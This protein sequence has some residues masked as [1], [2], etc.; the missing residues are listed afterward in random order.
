M[1]YPNGVTGPGVAQR[2]HGEFLQKRIFH[3]DQIVLI[4]GK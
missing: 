1:K 4:E 3:K 2:P